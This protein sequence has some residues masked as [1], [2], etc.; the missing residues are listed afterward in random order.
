MKISKIQIPLLILL[1]L[2]AAG[3]GYRMLQLYN[4][5][6]LWGHLPLLFFLSIWGA[7]ILI[8]GLLRKPD[9][10][11]NRYLGLAMLS[12][13]LLAAG[14]PPSPL[15]PLVFIGF[16]PLLIIEKELS[17]SGEEKIRRQVFRYAY[18]AFIF[19]NI[20]T[21]FWVANTAFIAGIFAIMANALLMCIPF[22][23]FH[24]TRKVFKG[25][26]GYLPLVVYWITFEYLHMQ[27][28]L[29]WPWLTLGNSFAEYPSWI[30]WYEYTGAFGGSLWALGMNVVLFKLWLSYKE[31]GSALWQEKSQWLQ[32]LFFLLAPIAASVL[33][34]TNYEEKGESTEI[35]IVQPNFEPHYQKFTVSPAMQ[36]GR[37]ISLSEKALSPESEYL[38]FPETSFGRINQGE[39]LKNPPIRDLKA[40]VEKYPKLNL[41]TGI[42]GHK[43][44][45][46]GEAHSDAVR[47]QVSSRGDTLFWEG[48]NSA[49]QISSGSDEM[50]IYLKSIHVPGAEAFP[51]R[52]LIFFL[53]PV[54]DALGGAVVLGRQKERSLFSSES[55]RV[56]PI[57]C[58]ES[59]F[60]EY[61][62]QYVRKGADL[63]FIVTNDGWWDNTAGH[64][65]HLKFAS[66]RA[67]ETRRA[68]ARSANTGV[69]CFINQ[70]GDILQPTH[71]GETTA[72]KGQL[73]RNTEI[74][75]YTRWQD[76]IARLSLFMSL[77]FLL[78]V[79]VKSWTSKL[80]LRKEE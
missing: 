24:Q 31:K 45:K 36:L 8:G 16:V 62:T 26:F 53:Q 73:Q 80:A 27:W 23:L 56:A 28:E 15:I 6:Q 52:K 19:W 63:L 12:G 14:F 18:H 68:I 17:E 32:P 61:V 40:M 46:P 37:F 75:F 79:T 20:L 60:G 67:I 48:Y 55:G 1:L 38:V 58:Y 30:Q 74:T 47:T 33:I 13:F 39:L 4:T 42:S 72:I 21:T 50:P 70:R 9:P 54:V 25:K 10:K 78:N 59:I 7:F 76:L 44:Y 34:Y 65:Q 64:R 29:T 77:L 2:V 5:D 3:S 22:L 35:V 51:Y 41:V 57:I 11:R 66:L 69:S 49:L 71:Y 43:I